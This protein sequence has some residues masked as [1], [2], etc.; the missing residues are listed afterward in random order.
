MKFPGT[1]L[2]SILLLLPALAGCGL[3]AMP[4]SA[5]A[6]PVGSL[7]ASSLGRDAVQLRWKISDTTVTGFEVTWR[8]E[9]MEDVGEASIGLQNTLRIDG[10]HAGRYFFQVT[11]LR[12]QQRLTPATIT[13]AAASRFDRDSATGAPL[14]LYE[15]YSTKAS[16]LVLDLASGVP[17]LTGLRFPPTYPPTPVA[18]MIYTSDLQSSEFSIGPLSAYTSLGGELD[19]IAAISDISFGVESL[20]NWFLSYSIDNY[21][22]AG[23]SLKAFNHLPASTGNNRGIGFFVRVGLGTAAVP[24]HYARVVIRNNGGRILQG[25]APDRYVELEVSFQIEKDLPFARRS[26]MPVAYRSE[27]RR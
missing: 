16:G 8:G 17:G 23:G 5:I 27:R 6:G 19:S 11:P 9:R 1:I 21:I 10:L 20:D 24:Y 26:P 3:D 14:R 4:T 7:E 2:L 22:G 18:L 13:W 15:L 25:S 12:N